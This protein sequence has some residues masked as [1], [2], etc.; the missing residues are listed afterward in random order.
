MYQIWLNN[1]CWAFGSSRVLFLAHGQL[2]STLESNFVFSGYGFRRVCPICIGS[3]LIWM[4][5]HCFRTSCGSARVTSSAFR[6]HFFIVI[7][8]LIGFDFAF[9]CWLSANVSPC[10]KRVSR[11]MRLSN[12]CVTMC[13]VPS[14]RR[15]ATILSISF[16]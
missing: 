9:T 10:W 11:K 2:P 5:A 4:F 12:G 14:S 3:S 15:S 13:Y 7:L 16:W 6:S 1:F 8:T